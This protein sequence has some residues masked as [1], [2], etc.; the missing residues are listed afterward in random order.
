[1]V[2]RDYEINK[3]VVEIYFILTKE[4]KSQH[5]LNL[6]K[7]INYHIIK[8]ESLRIF[9]KIEFMANEITCPKCNHEFTLSDVMTDELNV[10]LKEAKAK[11]NE[12]VIA[13]KKA[14]D[15]EYKNKLQ[16]AEK[17]ASK[18]ASDD[19][20]TKL[21]YFKKEVDDK[22]KLLQDLQRK[23]FEFIREK[24]EMESRQK[25]FEVEKQK[26]FLE[27]SGEIENNVIKREQELFDLKLKE[28]ETQMES[29]RK[30]IDDLKRKSEQ[31]SMQLQGE[32]QEL[33]LESILKEKFPFDSI[34]EVGKGVEG[35]DCIQIVKNNAGVECG[36]II[37]ES[38]RTKSW[39]NNWID[40]LKADMRNRTADVAILVTQTYPKGMD[41]FGEKDGIW[42]CNFS[43]VISIACIIRSGIFKVFDIQKKEENKGE[44]MHMLYDYLTG[45]EFRGQVEA[46]A[47]GFLSMKNSITKERM[48]M[49]KIWKEREKQLD[50]VLI[51][52]SSLFGSVKGIAGTSIANIPLL[53][54][55]EESNLIEN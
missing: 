36:R 5:I 47:E 18:K 2:L 27:K 14:K 49:E 3:F 40:K 42:I 26:Y 37:Y 6:L 4:N 20:A 16:S 53:D 30:T 34:E 51:N 9:D 33:L 29:M 55:D 12:D 1:M 35:A 10:Q 25:N 23:E 28:K 39:S 54:G 41:C 13:W 38:K 31:V 24:A 7:V 43:E 21:E 52:T 11:L 46:I 32:S 45:L 17:E 19:L 8:P 15:D 22:S 48:Q 50:K 44:K